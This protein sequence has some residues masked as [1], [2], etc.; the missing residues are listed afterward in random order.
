MLGLPQVSRTDDFAQARREPAGT[1]A[2]GP[3]AQLL[4]RHGEAR[5]IRH[6]FDHPTLAGLA[7]SEAGDLVVDTAAADQRLGD[8]DQW[9][10]ELEDLT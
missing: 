7:A 2:C 8:M 5:P 1:T 6:F 4:E 9:M 10:S 3:R